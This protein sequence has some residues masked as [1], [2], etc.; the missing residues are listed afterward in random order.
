VNTA[1]LAKIHTVEWTTA[2]LGNPALQIGMRANW[3]G[4]AGERIGRTFGRLSD[5]EVVSG[6]VGGPT[7]HFDVPYA[8]TEEFVAVYRMHPLI[9]DDYTLRSCATDALLEERDFPG[10]AGRQGL[11]LLETVAMDDLLYSFG[12]AHPGAVVLH[13]FPRAMQF[14]QRQDGLVQDLAATDILRTRELGVPRYNDFR[15]MLHMAP[16]A[17]FEDLTDNPRWR[18][19][20]RRV[21][22]DDVELLDLMVGMFAETP[23]AGFGFSDTA[24]RIFVL[25]ASRRLNSD[26]FF[27]TDF[28]AATY[29]QEGLDWVAD[30]DM[31]SVLLRHFPALTPALRGV[32]NAFAP[33]VR[34]A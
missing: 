27:T 24:F 32:R 22:D 18:E 29:S 34:V 10:M 17:R 1:L 30:N 3:W 8:L 15:R 16:I 28:N 4:L 5:S 13:N 7:N 26:R 9:P 31:S 14:L 12:V 6:I 23:P 20:L 19:E 11:E 21:Y 33:W 25:M 2:I